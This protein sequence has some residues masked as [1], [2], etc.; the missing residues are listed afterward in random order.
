MAL[1]RPFTRLDV[2]GRD[3]LGLLQV[4]CAY[5]DAPVAGTV[6]AE[7]VVFEPRAPAEAA[8]GTLAE[9]ALAIRDAAAWRRID[10][11]TVVMVPDFTFGLGAQR[12]RAI[13]VTAWERESFR[14]LD[15]V[16]RL[17][18]AGLVEIGPDFWVAPKQYAEQPGYQGLR[19]GFQ[20]DPADGQWKW[21]FLVRGEL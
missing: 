21:L 8:T 3:S 2:T 18:D 20:R 7:D 19:V 12:D 11:L 15:Q 1:P 9:F 10:S 4:T 5:C 14:E 17:L 6:A 16:P 13:T